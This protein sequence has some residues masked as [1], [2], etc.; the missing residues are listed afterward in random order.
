MNQVSCSWAG[1]EYHHQ[2][3]HNKHPRRTQKIKPLF[4]SLPSLTGRLSPLPSKHP[5]GSTV[6]GRLQRQPTKSGRPSSTPTP[7][8]FSSNSTPSSY[9]ITPRIGNS[10]WMRSIFFSDLPGLCRP[11]I[12]RPPDLRPALLLSPVK[13][14][15]QSRPGLLEIS[16]DIRSSPVKPTGG[17]VSQMRAPKRR[18]SRA[19]WS[20]R[21]QA[22]KKAQEV[23]SETKHMAFKLG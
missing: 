19:V 13:W 3:Q 1:G 2:T 5:E 7:R 14:F 11:Q 4:L 8:S 12:A 16:Q 17:R 15:P 10:L 22:L 6:P 21:P 20:Q 23:R 18:A 9:H